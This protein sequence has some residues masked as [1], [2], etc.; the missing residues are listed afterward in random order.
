MDL[1]LQEDKIQCKSALWQQR[2]LPHLFQ[3]AQTGSQT[4]M[5]NQE[6]LAGLKIQWMGYPLYLFYLVTTCVGPVV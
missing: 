1:P 6:P 2:Q 3:A 4:S 5:T